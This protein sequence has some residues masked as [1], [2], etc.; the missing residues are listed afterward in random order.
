MF[1]IYY[2]KD[3]NEAKR[4]FNIKQMPRELPHLYI[5]DPKS[6]VELKRKDASEGLQAA[7]NAGGGGNDSYVKKYQGFIFNISSPQ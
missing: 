1:D 5:I 3:E 2:C 4:Y 7:P 6:E